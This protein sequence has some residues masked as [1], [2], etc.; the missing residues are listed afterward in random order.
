MKKSTNNENKKLDLITC[1]VQRG[2][3][4][5]V[6]K[7]AMKAGAQGATVFFARGTGI[8]EKLGLLGIAIQPEKEVIMIVIESE[9][10]EKVFEAIVEAGKLRIPGHGFAF[11]NEIKKAV[12]LIEDF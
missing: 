4:D 2:K 9:L 6:V 7:A 1:I 12:G 11:I 8:R 5:R 3:A 10:T